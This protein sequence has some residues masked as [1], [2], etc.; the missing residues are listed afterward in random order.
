MSLIENHKIREVKY[1]KKEQQTTKDDKREQNRTTKSN[2]T[3]TK[4]NKRL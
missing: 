4:I 2:K 3:I 1:N